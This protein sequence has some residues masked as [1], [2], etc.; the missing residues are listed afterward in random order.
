MSKSKAKGTAFERRVVEY[1]VIQGFPYA[2]RRALEGTNDRGDISG[3]P[4]VVIECKNT[5]RL[6]LAVWQDETL[7]EQKN[8]NAPVAF[9]VFPRR[10]HHIGK[11]HVLM[12]L[13]QVLSLIG[14]GTPKGTEDRRKA[15]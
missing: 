2:E 14:D 5:K 8:A 9:C 3:I 1:L 11:A 13:D 15:E 6:E 12:T 4:G 10:S 7:A